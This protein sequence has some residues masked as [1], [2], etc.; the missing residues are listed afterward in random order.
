MNHVQMLQS[1]QCWEGGEGDRGLGLKGKASWGLGVVSFPAAKPFSP[2]FCVL[3]L[4]LPLL[5]PFCPPV[6]SNQRMPHL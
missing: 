5:Q 4:F 6:P 3:S 1:T 2:P